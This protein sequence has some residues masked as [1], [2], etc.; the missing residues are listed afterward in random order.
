MSLVVNRKNRAKSRSGTAQAPSERAL[1]MTES[2]VEIDDNADML[3]RLSPGEYAQVVAHARFGEHQRGDM[4]FQQGLCHDGIFVIQSGRVRSF[5]VGPNA[6][7]ITLAYW[8]AGHFAGG[9]EI[10]GGGEHMWSAEAVER[11]EILHL[12]GTALRTLVQK[13][14]ALAVGLIEALAYKGKCY[15]ALLQLLGTRSVTN[16]LA[17]LICTLAERA[18]APQAGPTTIDM[19][20]TN[21][22]LANMVGATRQWVSL[23][24]R[25]F[26]S[27]GLIA[28]EGRR[29]VV[30]NP[31]AL[32]AISL[33]TPR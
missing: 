5:Y 7:E 13:I 31:K 1:Y 18:R 28:S 12:P 4:V 8:T 6:R 26:E 29:M 33:A 30:L 19:F 27:E 20:F 2:L 3:G 32:L 10:F 24:L 9:P 25:R 23:T 14:P 16:R 21:E 22:E 17:H 11:S 15:S